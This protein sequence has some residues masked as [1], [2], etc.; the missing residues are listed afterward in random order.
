VDVVV[1]CYAG[2]RAEQEPRAFVL[3]GRRLRVLGIAEQ[4]VEPG[5]RCFRVRAEDGHQY[6]LRYEA[7]RDAWSLVETTPADA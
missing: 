5:T 4:W 3:H 6:L 1:E 7:H 2:Y